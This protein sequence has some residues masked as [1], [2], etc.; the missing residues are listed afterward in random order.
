MHET[1]GESSLTSMTHSQHPRS[2]IV[3]FLRS[4]TFW[5]GLAGVAAIPF[6][7]LAVEFARWNRFPG[8]SAASTEPPVS[9]PRRE[10][11]QAQDVVDGWLSR[12]RLTGLAVCVGIAG[13]VEWCS[14]HGY[15]DMDEGKPLTADT[16]LRLGSVSKPVTSILL[17]RLVE[18]G[19]LDLDQPIGDLKPDLP[20]HLHPVTVRQLASHTAG[21]RHY[22]WRLGWPPHETASRVA[23]TSVTDSLAIFADDPL[24]FPPG[25]DFTYS[26][27]GY[28]LLGA[29]LEQASG[30]HFG[31]LLEHEINGPL[32][33]DSIDLDSADESVRWARHYEVKG[34][35][36]RQALLVDNS[37]AWPG[38][39]LRASA[40]DL[41]KLMSG[42]TELG[43]IGEETLELI[44]TPQTLPDG[45]PN[46]ENYALGWRLGQTQKFLGGET[47]YRV[48]HHGGVSSGSSAFVVLFPDDSLA[49]A[50]LANS[51][52]GSS[53]LAELAFEVAE[54]FM[55]R[56][57]AD[58]SPA[59]VATARPRTRP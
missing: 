43:V 5:L 57:V 56:I 8:I 53:P 51:R 39:G 55:A 48:A 23:Y 18:R 20:P 26:S 21:V 40:S 14:A 10:I 37:R 36:Y 45:S 35:W 44:L 52:T 25:S 6:I 12:T 19:I 54:P 30:A 13:D 41:V 17:A 24:L 3:R 38:A 15:S 32:G 22:R 31:H 1:A 2:A 59:T 33:L 42:L 11:E 50:V 58:G 28:T 46:P 34:K 7:A 29:V 27:H 9:T 4:R 16:S 49:V 47:S